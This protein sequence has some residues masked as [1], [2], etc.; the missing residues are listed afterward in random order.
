MQNFSFSNLRTKIILTL[1]IF[2]R[3]FAF[4]Q[5]QKTVWITRDCR[6]FYIIA[7]VVRARIWSQNK[8]QQNCKH[9]RQRTKKSW[10]KR[11]FWYLFLLYRAGEFLGLKNKFRARIRRDTLFLRLF[12]CCC[13]RV[14][15]FLV[16]ECQIYSYTGR[17][18]GSFIW[19]RNW[20]EIEQ[21]VVKWME[22]FFCFAFRYINII[23]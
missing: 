16:S 5:Y 13:Y 9:R 11:N 23:F 6:L 14:Y 8:A 12:E 15:K 2:Q 20:N 17:L 18:N 21:H 7:Q 22:F 10:T 4:D 19:N 3:S 1:F